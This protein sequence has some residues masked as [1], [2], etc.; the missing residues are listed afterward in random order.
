MVG[1]HNRSNLKSATHDQWSDP[2]EADGV[3]I[4]ART[5]PSATKENHKLHTPFDRVIAMQKAAYMVG[6]TPELVIEGQEAQQSRLNEELMNLSFDQG[7][8]ELGQ[9]ATGRGT[10]FALLF[11]PPKSK[12][13]RITFPDNWGCFVLYSPET[14][15]PEYGVRYWV[16][17]RTE[18][19]K[20][21]DN[22]ESRKIN[23]EFYTVK[24]VQTISGSWGAVDLSEPELHMFNGVPLIEFANNTERLS[25]VELTMSLQDAY[26][27]ADSDLSSEISQLRLAYLSLPDSE[28]DIDADWLKTLKQTGVFIGDGKFIEK[29]INAEAVENIKKDLEMRIYKYSNSYNPDELGADK[30]LTAFQIQQKLLRL[31]SSAKETEML[32]KLALAD[33]IRMIAEFKNI[34]YNSDSASWKF[35]R[36]TPRN[37]MED[38]K[39][40][41]E[42]G[43]KFSQ[44]M[45]A[46]IFP[47]ELD[48]EAN[49][50]ELAE[51]TPFGGG[52]E[53]DPLAG[54]GG[55]DTEEAIEVAKL[56]GIQISAANDIIGAVGRK[57]LSR[58]AGLNQLKTFLG[59][60]DQQANA[61]M[62]KVIVK[63]DI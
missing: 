56:S 16:E 59:L 52:S 60:S 62:G 15:R 24:D 51:E 47:F 26:D 14:G 17:L 53:S 21:P 50:Q 11:T 44:K 28:V 30:A 46:R 10:S 40:A 5:P 55:G 36:N 38:L 12:D 35:T 61:V 37:A 13:M 27:I 4:F 23:G 43:F 48:Q 54:I 58:E 34:P 41:V 3:P 29:N 20:Q 19:E 57:E 49:E 33:M 25:D 1:L 2:R 9:S 8:S 45:M 42:S 63:N 22:D 7:I 6:I 32:F 31:E 39:T 18:D